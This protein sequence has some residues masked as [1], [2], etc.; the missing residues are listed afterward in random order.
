MGSCEVC[1]SAA[2]QR[3]WLRRWPVREGRR[4]GSEAR[5]VRVV[6][7]EAHLQAWLHEGRLLVRGG[8]AYG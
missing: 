8:W 2:I 3:L 5:D 6:L 1:P 4:V 7:C